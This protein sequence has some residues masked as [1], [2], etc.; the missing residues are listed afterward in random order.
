[1]QDPNWKLIGRFIRGPYKRFVFEGELDDVKVFNVSQPNTFGRQIAPDA[2]SGGYHK[3]EGLA[4]AKGF[5]MSD[6][7]KY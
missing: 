3:L 6:F 1:M 2:K 7:V 4:Q 5:A